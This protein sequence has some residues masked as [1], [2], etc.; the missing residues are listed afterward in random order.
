VAVG[1]AKPVGSDIGVEAGLATVL[2]SVFAIFNG[3]ERPVFG[4]LT[5]KLTP[6]NNFICSGCVCITPDVAGPY[7]AGIPTHFRHPLGLP[8][9]WL[10]IAPTT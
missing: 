8:G 7:C 2:V 4:M 5:D 10:A 6:R 3:F 1:I 9:R